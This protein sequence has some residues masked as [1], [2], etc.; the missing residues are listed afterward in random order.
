M[1]LN[2]L[3]LLEFLINIFRSIL[4]IVFLFSIEYFSQVFYNKYVSN[5]STSLIEFIELI[6]K[7]SYPDSKDSVIEFIS[8]LASV[9]GVLLALFYPI[10]ATIA[11][12]G[13]SK[14]NSS[15]RNLIFIEPVTQNYLRKLAFLTAF[16]I[17]TLLLI[18]F[19]YH[20]GNLVLSF[21]MYLALSNLFLLLKLGA[22]VYSLFEPDT[23]L[24][25]V[26]NEIKKEINGVTISS[27]YWSNSN[28]QNY[29]RGKT[30]KNL[31]K[32]RLI[33]E[34]SFEAVA[35]NNQSFLNTISQ[36][37]SLLNYYLRIKNKIP[38]NSKWFK[39]K[40]FHKSF[41]ETS[42]SERQISIDTKTYIQHKSDTNYFWF[43]EDIF[44]IFSELGKKLSSISNNGIKEEYFQKSI[45][46]LQ[47]FGH[48]FEF[49]LANKLLNQN[50]FIVENSIIEIDTPSYQNSKSNLAL[51][52]S[53]I[54]SIGRFQISFFRTVEE[55]DVDTFNSEIK[56]I[57]WNQKDSIYRSN[58]PIHLHQFIEKYYTYLKNEIIVEGKKTTPDWFINQHLS[59][60]YLLLVERVFM[61][62]LKQLDYFVIPLI[63]KSNEN[64]DYILVSF[65]SHL[66]IELLNKI[67]F[68]VK[69]ILEITDQF[70]KNNMY[71]NNFTWKKV[72]IDKA[73]K[74][75]AT[76]REKMI[77]VSSDN[78]QS[79]FN[80]DWN[81]DYPDVFARSFTIIAEELVNCLNNK[82]VKKFERLFKPFLKSS[83]GAFY[84]L[85]KRYDGKFSNEF[86]VIY[87]LHIELFQISGIGYVYT[88]LTGIPF[89]EKIVDCWNEIPFTKPEI[90][91]F[92]GSYLFY[93]HNKYGTGHNYTE[94]L[95]RSS[96]LS[97]FIKDNAINIEDFR[98]NIIYRFI[99]E[100]NFR[101]KYFEEIFLEFHILTFMDSKESAE[102]LSRAN[103]R[104][105]FESILFLIKEN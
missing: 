74:E 40:N 62:V 15:I 22:G 52:E 19:G 27:I 91:L 71:K 80:I 60:E 47:Y 104:Q 95:N 37:Y 75:I 66:T 7:P 63:K 87:Q 24:Q 73:S 29:F 96:K 45:N 88:Q 77:L 35:I 17:F 72:D 30:E 92:V 58:L 25:I 23:L 105:V 8:L 28:F 41:F 89:W 36:T 13:Y 26:N 94:N 44:E 97:K 101:N 12:T 86:E 20:P 69:M 57:D 4:L 54:Y 42:S 38:V 34:L 76:I 68:H 5:F 102:S 98:N 11:S 49:K 46:T 3:Y 83:L 6:P 33:T 103:Q 81:E 65:I 14:V 16:S 1:S 31:E 79:I 21:L 10:L 51:V 99:G 100:S 48:N 64:K 78:M 90:E 53:I 56:K 59:A 61:E 84:S 18:T 93:K 70:D 85:H 82:D 9:S 32:I 43:E 55:L 50:L 39:N 2:R 67:E